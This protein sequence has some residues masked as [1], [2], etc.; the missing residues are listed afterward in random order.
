[1]NRLDAGEATE[2]DVKVLFDASTHMAGRTICALA[3]GAAAPTL[4][5]LKFF[6]EDVQAKLV[7]KSS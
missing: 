4:S 7:E 5:L 3:E 2:D 1:M 6:P